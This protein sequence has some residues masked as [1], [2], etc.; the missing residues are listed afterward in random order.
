MEALLLLVVGHVFDNVDGVRLPDDLGHLDVLLDRDMDLLDDFVRPV[1]G[2]VHLPDDLERHV[3]DYFIRYRPLDL[4][5]LSLV[6]GVWYMLHDLYGDGVGLR[7]GNFHLLADRNGHGLWDGDF[8]V[9]RDL[10]GNA[11]DDVLNHSF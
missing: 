9:T 5:V 4:M 6:D 1:D 7:H 10:D 11:A 8:N 3:F 2:N